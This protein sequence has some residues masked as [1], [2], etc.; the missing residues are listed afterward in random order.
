MN[1]KNSF[2]TNLKRIEC[3]FNSISYPTSKTTPNP[4]YNLKDKYLFTPKDKY[5]YKTIIEKLYEFT[6][7]RI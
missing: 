1:Y 3:R 2:I 5:L 6:T 4:T 7:E